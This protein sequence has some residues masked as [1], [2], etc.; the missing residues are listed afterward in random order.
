MAAAKKIYGADDRLLC[1]VCNEN[2]ATSEDIPYCIL[3]SSKCDGL[4]FAQNKVSNIENGVADLIMGFQQRGLN[5][6][7]LDFQRALES[8]DIAKKKLDKNPLLRLEQLKRGMTT[9]L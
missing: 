1:V 6:I 9:E 8:L 3:C 4:L 2:N 5:E 7:A